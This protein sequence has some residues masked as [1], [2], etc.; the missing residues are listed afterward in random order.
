MIYLYTLLLYLLIPFVLLSLYWRG[1][2][3]PEYRRRWA[4]RFGFIAALPAAGC[5]WIH[6]VSVGE[7]R[8]ALPLI[9]ALQKRWPTTA[10]LVTTTTPTGSRQ[11]CELLGNAVWHVY[12]PYDL[13]AAVTRFLS[14]ARPRLALIMETELWP[15]LFARCASLNIPLI[16]ANARL[17]ERSARRYQRLRPLVRQMLSE[18]TLIAAQAEA[19]A[20]RFRELGAP[21]VKVTGNL[22]FDL[23]LPAGLPD[24]GRELRRGLGAQRPVLIAASTHPGEEEQL[25][26][27]PS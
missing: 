20:A 9:R 2:K 5:I 8:A 15:N 1:R 17:S 6:A 11:V 16:V 27:K 19:D 18:A 21:R 13:P 7:T 14:A 23:T 25:I 10:L 24:Q 26:P 22:K 4:E 3:I 12:A